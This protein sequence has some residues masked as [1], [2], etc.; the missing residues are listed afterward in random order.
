MV[1]DLMLCTNFFIFT[2]GPGSGKTAVLN[3]LNTWGYL[4]VSEVARSIIQKQQADGGDAIHTGNR[5]A[6]RDLMLE[7]SIA[8]YCKMQSEEK[9]YFSIGESR[10]CM[11]TPKHFV[12]RRVRK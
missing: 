9:L 11:V 6:F 7:Q 5:K 8:D 2:G 12:V 3:E 10:I 4:T 1:E